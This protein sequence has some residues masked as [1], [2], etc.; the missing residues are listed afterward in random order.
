M[1]LIKN[2]LS[3]PEVLPTITRN[4]SPDSRPDKN[5]T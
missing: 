3:P 2:T 5:Q 4:L 1:I